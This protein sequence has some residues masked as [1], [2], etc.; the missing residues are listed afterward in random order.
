[1]W[2]YQGF[3]L[4]KVNLIMLKATFI[5]TTYHKYCEYAALHYPLVEIILLNHGKYADL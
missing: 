3:R 5:Q 1:M 4:M 2:V